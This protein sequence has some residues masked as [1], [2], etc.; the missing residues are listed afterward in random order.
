MEWPGLA[1]V[2]QV[3][4]TFTC[5]YIVNFTCRY[6]LFQIPRR[7]YFPKR[8][9]RVALHCNALCPLSHNRSPI[10]KARMIAPASKQPRHEN[11]PIQ[12]PQVAVPASSLRIE[13]LLL[14]LKILESEKPDDGRGRR[15]CISLCLYSRLHC[16]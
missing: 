15:M 2:G 8:C 5:R 13:I 16:L 9:C 6:I 10:L 14:N 11:H 1:A 7:N 12:S 4:L 3:T